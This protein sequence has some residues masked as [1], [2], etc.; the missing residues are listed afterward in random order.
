VDIS[1]YILLSIGLFVLLSMVTKGF[2]PNRPLRT[3]RKLSEVLTIM[4][5]YLVFPV[6]V[7]L[8]FSLSTGVVK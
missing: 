6:L 1:S 3:K 4:I 2:F 8:A 7:A 5:V